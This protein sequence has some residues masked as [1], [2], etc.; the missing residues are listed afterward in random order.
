MSAE[1]L[2]T[3]YDCAGEDQGQFTRQTILSYNGAENV[4]PTQEDRPLS[5]TCR[6]EGPISKH[7]PI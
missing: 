1:G 5:R 6:G 7:V 2:G 4:A 3:K